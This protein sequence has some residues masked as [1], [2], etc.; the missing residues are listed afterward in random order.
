M[1]SGK[2]GVRRTSVKNIE[3]LTGIDRI[4]NYT[5]ERGITVPTEALKP[6]GIDSMP[7]ILI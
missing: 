4:Q 7:T 5:K 3:L 1:E 2:V 6:K